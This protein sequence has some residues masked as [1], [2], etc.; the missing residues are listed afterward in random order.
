[1]HLVQNYYISLDVYDPFNKQFTADRK[2][3]SNV[4]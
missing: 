1:M 2:I 3:Y 4:R